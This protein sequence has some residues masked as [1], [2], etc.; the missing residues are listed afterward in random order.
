MTVNES[1]GLKCEG[2]LGNVTMNQI[3]SQNI[4]ED[5]NSD[6]NDL[7]QMDVDSKGS[8]VTSEASTLSFKIQGRVMRAPLMMTFKM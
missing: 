8:V 2:K 4:M 7:S 1:K 5:S 6:E 3:E